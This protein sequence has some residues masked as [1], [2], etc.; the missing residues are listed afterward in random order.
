MTPAGATGPTGDTGPT[1]P[2]GTPGNGAIIPFA[3]GLPVAPTSLVLGLAGLPALVG[4][5]TSTVLATALGSTINLTGGTGVLAN[6]AFSVPRDGTITS[7]AAY[8]SVV[9]G[10]TL[11]GT[12]IT[13]HAQLYSSPTPDNTF[14]PIAGAIVDLSPTIGGIISIGDITSGITSGLSIPVTTGTR[15][16][17]VFTITSSG[18]SLANTLTGYASAGVNIS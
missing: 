6:L 14:S 3:S 15:L 4:F 11:L 7:I 2:T 18:V 12:T 5:G 16:L 8:F 10:L 13:V 17:M 1:G 9:V